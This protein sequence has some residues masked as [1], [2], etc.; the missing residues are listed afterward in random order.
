[1]RQTAFLN[2]KGVT[3]VEVMISLVI[4]LLVFMGLIQA[5]I[6]SINSNMR[7]LVRDGATLVAAEYMSRAKATPIDTLTATVCGTYTTVN[8]TLNRQVRQ[9]LQKYQVAT[10]GCFTDATK[11]NAQ[12]YV[13]VTYTY[14]GDAAAVL[15][16]T[17]INSIVQRPL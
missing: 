9:L 7:N 12:V 11:Q 14:P 8:V 3:L 17:I 15:Q 1:M 6:V 5:S 16:T 2:S 13:T 4:L 10:S